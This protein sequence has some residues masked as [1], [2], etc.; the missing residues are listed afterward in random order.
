MSELLLQP[1]PDYPSIMESPDFTVAERAEIRDRKFY[2]G[3]RSDEWVIVDRQLPIRLSTRIIAG[4]VEASADEGAAHRLAIELLGNNGDRVAVPAHLR[5]QPIVLTRQEDGRFAG[6]LW[7]ELDGLQLPSENTYTFRLVIDGSV[8]RETP[9]RVVYRE[10]SAIVTL[11]AVIQDRQG[12]TP[13]EHYLSGRV[14]ADVEAEGRSAVNVAFR[15]KQSA[16]STTFGDAVEILAPTGYDDLLSD[17]GLRSELDRYYRELAPT[18]NA[19]IAT[20]ESNLI[21]GRLRTV[22]LTLPNSPAQGW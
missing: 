18:P 7:S 20:L 14:I 19:I 6:A 4:V 11:K 3:G 12:T 21:G 5:E 16:G 13:G 15:V 8:I 2:I 17:Q 9:L 1:L 22:F 10:R